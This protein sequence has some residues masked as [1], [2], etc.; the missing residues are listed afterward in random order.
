MT[1]LRAR[2]RL[3]YF[4]VSEDEYAWL[5]SMCEATGARSLSD[6]MRTF[7]QERRN[8]QARR[9]D[10][11]EALAERIDRLTALIEEMQGKAGRR[12]EPKGAGRV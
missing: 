5:Q 8:G 6:L 2:T 12:E 4:R 10:G 3:I 1:V 7:L 11:V 9:A